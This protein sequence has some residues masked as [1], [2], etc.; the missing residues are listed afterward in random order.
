MTPMILGFHTALVLE[1]AEKSLAAGQRLTTGATL[2]TV[3]DLRQ[4]VANELG[5]IAAKEYGYA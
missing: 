4:L 2:G 5:D 1:A 3:V